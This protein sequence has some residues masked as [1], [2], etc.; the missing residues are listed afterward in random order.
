MIQIFP[1]ELLSAT[2]VNP[3]NNL[4]VLA[5]SEVERRREYIDLFESK[6]SLPTLV[7]L[8]KQCLMNN[9]PQRPSAEELLTRLQALR[10]EVDGEYAGSYPIRLDLVRVRLAKEAKE[11]DRRIAELTQQQ[12]LD[13]VTA[14]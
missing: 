6:S 10:V 11:K 13:C 4:E 3:E 1:G 2:Y 14:N 8:V 12:V 9:P 5:R 7:E